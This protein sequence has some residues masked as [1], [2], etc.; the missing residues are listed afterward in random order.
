MPSFSIVIPSFNRADVIERT[1]QQLAAQDYPADRYELIVV[2]DSADATPDIVRRFAEDAK[3]PVRLIDDCRCIPAIKRNVG[4]AAA[5]GDYVLFMNDD[6]WCEPD[7][8]AEHARTHASWTE[9]VAV[10]G[11]VE[12]SPEM[13]RSAFLDWYRPFAYHLLREYANKPVPY[14]FCWSMN[15]SLPRERMLSEGITFH[16]QWSEIGHEDVELGYRWIKAGH[17]VIY[18]PSALSIH[19]H[20]HT[21]RSACRLQESIGRGLRD[22]ERR[23]PEP[24]LLERY[25]VF[26]WRNTPRAV[27]RGLARHAL[28]NDVTG[29]LLENW[30]SRQQR[31]TPLSRWLYWKVLLRHTDR[32]YRSP[33]PLS[34]WE[35]VGVRAFL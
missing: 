20:P 16:E 2:D 18:N 4:L 30:L 9:P 23:I 26:S 17:Q 35:R 14:Y 7:L 22:L 24:R 27:A 31:N 34:L 10:L 8:L 6:A 5:T 3:F 29:P 13:P 15:L 11:R 19:Y 12:Q 32:G 28:V 1:L 21:L 33:C 25:G